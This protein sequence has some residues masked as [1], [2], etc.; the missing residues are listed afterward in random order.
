MPPASGLRKDV[1]ILVVGAGV[2]GVT[3]AYW[4]SS[5]YDCRILLVD[6]ERG[7][8]RHTSSRNTG[9]IHRPFY[10]NPET[11]KT[12]AL[13]A[14]RSYPLWRDLAKVHGLPWNPVGTL[15]VALREDDVPLLEKYLRWGA[16]NGMENTE[17]ELLDA[18]SVKSVEPE[19]QCRAALHSKTDT[20]VDFGRFTACVHQLALEQGLSFQ[21]GLQV[22]SLKA[23][24]AAL[25]ASFSGDEHLAGVKCS[26]LINA[27]GGASV[28]IAH[29]MGLASEY[30]TLN[31]RGE[32]WVVD[33]PFASRIGRNVYSLPRHPRFPF[34]DPHF[35]VRSDGMRQIGPNAVMVTDPYVYQG[36][37]LYSLPRLFAS[38]KCPKLNLLRDADFL[39]MVAGEWRT[40]LS[41][42]VMCERVRRFIPGLDHRALNS[43]GVSGVRA[44]VVGKEGFVPEAILVQ[45][46]RSVH[47]L[48]YNSPGATGA[49]SYSASLVARLREAGLLDGFRRKPYSPAGGIWDFDRAVGLT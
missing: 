35:I 11:K 32:Y 16:D 22:S 28:D 25:D 33:E 19:V 34:L 6:R 37:G 23:E 18:R 49:P 3:T 41:K 29:M 24:G 30:S 15:E 45:D 5:L 38:P 9:V 2:L 17:L 43:R 14:M 21:G 42:R 31:F 36:L 26:L 7:V 12:F 27:A 46:E 8:A 47:I 48:N 20:S 40:S 44:S 10:L 1:D 39:S 4:L 13:S